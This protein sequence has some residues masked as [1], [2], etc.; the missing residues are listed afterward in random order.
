MGTEMRGPTRQESLASRSETEASVLA[1]DEHA[2]QRVRRKI[3]VAAVAEANTEFLIE[4]HAIR[5]KLQAR[6]A[7][8][9]VEKIDV[10]E[11]LVRQGL[12]AIN[13]FE[14]AVR[15][16]TG[17]LEDQTHDW[18]LDRL[19]AYAVIVK[20]A[21]QKGQ[22]LKQFFDDSARN[23][24]F[25]TFMDDLRGNWF[26]KAITKLWR[27][28]V[29]WFPIVVQ[30]TTRQMY[31][32]AR[33]AV[34]HVLSDDHI[35]ALG[36]DAEAQAREA[37]KLQATALT[38]ARLVADLNAIEQGESRGELEIEVGIVGQ[39]KV[40][41][42]RLIE[43]YPAVDAGEIDAEYEGY[44][45]QQVEMRRAHPGAGCF[46]T[47]NP[48][49]IEL[50]LEYLKQLKV[51]NALEAARAAAVAA[52]AAAR[53]AFFGALNHVVDIDRALTQLTTDL[54]QHAPKTPERT[55]LQAIN[56]FFTGL[57]NNVTLRL[58]GE[59]ALTDFLQVWP[60]VPGVVRTE[61]LTGQR[62]LANCLTQ[63]ENPPGNLTDTIALV[64][65]GLRLAGQANP[66]GLSTLIAKLTAGSDDKKLEPIEA[67]RELDAAI[68]DLSVEMHLGETLQTALQ[69]WANR[70]LQNK[71]VSVEQWL[72]DQYI[73]EAAVNDFELG[74]N[75]IKKRHEL[76]N[77]EGF[78]LPSFADLL[79]D[80]L[81]AMRSEGPGN[82]SAVINSIKSIL[83]GYL[84]YVDSP[85][86]RVV[87]CLDLS[88]DDDSLKLFQALRLKQFCSEIV[89]T[90]TFTLPVGEKLLLQEIE[91]EANKTI[92]LFRRASYS[93]GPTKLVLPQSVRGV[94]KL[95]LGDF[96]AA[97]TSAPLTVTQR[98]RNFCVLSE[99]RIEG[100]SVFSRDAVIALRRQINEELP[101]PISAALQPGDDVTDAALLLKK[102]EVTVLNEALSQV[103]QRQEALGELQKQLQSFGAEQNN[104]EKIS[105]EL[106]NLYGAEQVMLVKRMR[107][108]YVKS[109]GQYLQNALSNLTVEQHQRLARL[110]L[111]IPVCMEDYWAKI[112]SSSVDRWESELTQEL[113][114]VTSLQA[115]A[116]KLES[117]S[118]YF[119][120]SFAAIIPILKR[121]LGDSAVDLAFVQRLLAYCSQVTGELSAYDKVVLEKVKVLTTAKQVQ[122]AAHQAELPGF[123]KTYEEVEVENLAEA[124]QKNQLLRGALNASLVSAKADALMDKLDVLQGRY[125]T[126][127]QLTDCFSRLGSH[128]FSSQLGAWHQA[129]VGVLIHAE[130]KNLAPDEAF[131]LHQECVRHKGLVDVMA[132]VPHPAGS[133]LASELNALGMAAGLPVIGAVLQ[134]YHSLLNPVIADQLGLIPQDGV[135]GVELLE[136]TIQ[137]L[138]AF[139]AIKANVLAQ[140][141]EKTAV[142]D[143]KRLCSKQIAGFGFSDADFSTKLAVVCLAAAHPGLK[144]G[145]LLALGVSGVTSDQLLATEA[146]KMQSLQ[147]MHNALTSYGDGLSEGMQK[148][149]RLLRNRPNDFDNL[150]V[151]VLAQLALSGLNDLSEGEA[152]AADRIKKLFAVRVGELKPRLFDKANFAE[153]LALLYHMQ[154]ASKGAI[155]LKMLGLKEVTQES[156]L[157]AELDDACNSVH[158]VIDAARVYNA[159][160]F[161]EFS[162]S[163][164]LDYAD[165]DNDELLV[166][167]LCGLDACDQALQAADVSE[168]LRRVVEK[169]RSL[170]QEKFEARRRPL[171]HEQ[172]DHFFGSLQAV[173]ER[174]GQQKVRELLNTTGEHAMFSFP[175]ALQQQLERIDVAADF[176][177]FIKHAVF[178]DRLHDLI[179]QRLDSV[180]VFTPFT[181]GLMTTFKEKLANQ[182]QQFLLAFRRKL[183]PA[184]AS[185]QL[186]SNQLEGYVRLISLA[187]P[188]DVVTG[189]T[190]LTPVVQALGKRN[191]DF[192]RWIL[193][194]RDLKKKQVVKTVTRF[195]KTKKFLGVPKLETVKVAEW[196]ESQDKSPLSGADCYLLEDCDVLEV[197]AAFN[198]L[199]DYKLLCKVLS[200]AK[201]RLN[202]INELL[203]EMHVLTASFQ[204]HGFARPA[205]RSLKGFTTADFMA[206]IKRFKGE[207]NR[208]T[209]SPQDRAMA[210]AGVSNCLEQLLQLV[211]ESHGGLNVYMSGV[212]ARLGGVISLIDVYFVGL[213]ATDVTGV[214]PSAQAGG[215]GAAAGDQRVLAQGAKQLAPN[216]LELLQAITG[217][218]GRDFAAEG[219]LEEVVAKQLEMERK[220]ELAE[221]E[222]EAATSSSM[223]R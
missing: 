145:D 172:L 62:A 85:L 202:R 205:N 179:Q 20:I 101:G 160:L 53:T 54:N 178:M 32:S 216:Q 100:H 91:V 28:F 162:E 27:G 154:G 214:L 130:L 180:E 182:R 90:H 49:A 68:S 133:A 83:V 163:V 6:L 58:V 103:L 129:Q 210:E 30:T 25:S 215:G 84:Q 33:A 31:V 143:I 73:S 167:I 120:T 29:S 121:A 156:L 199:G 12:D 67:Y 147:A 13:E 152:A 137:C 187:Y 116:E 222:K 150:R 207:V 1:A 107:D 197:E 131:K 63:L 119:G 70:H 183:A 50:R 86:K 198:A 190:C 136:Q 94:V 164:S 203:R 223:S 221:T 52:E 148:C 66:V 56:D 99:Q 5:D 23:H 176:P 39:I 188:D 123:L 195:S 124:V 200:F 11:A 45:R 78:T 126:Y 127:R 17:G 135:S 95:S 96:L 171:T 170:L 92:A 111:E 21:Y 193:G 61:F 77:E 16:V 59:Q 159:D 55:P 173:E 3:A 118:E 47:K 72:K 41:N 36:A 165:E 192:T 19:R 139:R 220:R 8:T 181:A 4:L 82:G 60:H 175:V 140:Q 117:Y 144:P 211:I 112:K 46:Q 161:G 208:I 134:K 122:L 206:A 43:T 34:V 87:L 149:L 35:R 153:K 212:D 22:A 69:A 177:G 132:D 37:D 218:F 109:A 18:S 26:Q 97:L 102:Q 38:T 114:Q 14:D 76:P 155:C 80:K 51:A 15:A 57:P 10:V 71:K 168:P 108:A 89:R 105:T 2:V 151:A 141:G 48:E 64:E 169:T 79:Q 186:N 209:L 113:S 115:V 81:H 174:L 106:A 7:D 104:Y 128:T 88:N 201:V 219:A 196:V 191:L 194:R 185:S 213:T 42:Q 9:R 75:A 157:Q 146:Q 158:A 44:K 184:P 74:L 204:E 24:G 166:N 93:S 65:A 138:L 98:L 142:S 40:S 125:D 189:L 110:D 217:F